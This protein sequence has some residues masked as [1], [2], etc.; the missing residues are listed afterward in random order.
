M[1]GKDVSSYREDILEV[2]R[3]ICKPKDKRREQG[4]IWNDVERIWVDMH[5]NNL[6]SLSYVLFPVLKT[7]MTLGVCFKLESQGLT[8]VVIL[9]KQ[10]CCHIC[11]TDCDTLVVQIL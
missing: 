11:W 10:T 9:T 4:K 6:R 5:W 7:I 3:A 8:H 1:G 2:C